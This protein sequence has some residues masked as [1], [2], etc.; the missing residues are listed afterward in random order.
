MEL[1]LVLDQPQVAGPLA[2]FPVFSDAPS[3]PDYVPGPSAGDLIAVGERDDGAAV[4][5]LLV[6]NHAET[7][8][9]LVEGETL[10]GAKQNRTLN[11]SVLIAANT[12]TVIPVSCLEAG[13]WDAPKGATRS[14]RHAPG[15]LRKFKTESV[16]RS[17]ARG[18]G[19]SSDQGEVWAAVDRYATRFA[20]ESPTAALEDVHGAIDS[21]VQRLVRELRPVPEQRGVIVATGST[22]RSLDLFDKADTL[23][24]YWDGLMRGYAM[25]AIGQPAT[26]ATLA[27]AKA[28]AAML[29]EAQL[30]EASGAGLGDELHLSSHQVTGVGLRW[31]GAVCHLAAFAT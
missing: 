31:E 17:V 1:Q 30:T 14:P 6:W 5:E 7:P 19:R 10:V 25:D 2:L 13:R 28:F 23:A 16:N 8:V 11:L 27:D 18:T 20:V 29:S 4:P 21:D 3:A 15:D 12:K 24:V 26:T 22:V 9:L